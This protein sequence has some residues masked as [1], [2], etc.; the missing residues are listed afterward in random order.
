MIVIEKEKEKVIILTS[1]SKKSSSNRSA[2]SI[3]NIRIF[4]VSNAPHSI[5]ARTLPGVPIT[6]WHPIASFA[7]VGLEYVFIFQLL[8]QW[9]EGKRPRDKI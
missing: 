5:N 4:E 2:S 8:I 6:M 9:E 1:F 7:W 3:I